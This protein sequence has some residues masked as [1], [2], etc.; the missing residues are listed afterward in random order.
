MRRESKNNSKEN[1]QNTKRER[2]ENYKN[3]QRQLMKQILTL[4]YQLKILI[5][6]NNIEE[7]F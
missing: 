7:N 2:E 5:V 4:K 6:K 1:Y 3:S